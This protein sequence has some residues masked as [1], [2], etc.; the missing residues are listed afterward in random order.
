MKDKITVFLSVWSPALHVTFEI[1]LKESYSIP[2]KVQY[3]T[4]LLPNADKM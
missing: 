4:T 2:S 3:N 1:F